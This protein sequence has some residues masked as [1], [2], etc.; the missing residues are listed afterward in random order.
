[1]KLALPQ[2]RHLSLLTAVILIM[3]MILPAFA[4]GAS[5]VSLSDIQNHWASKSLTDWVDKGL[6]QGYEDGTFKPNDEIKRAEF[7]ALV[8]RVFG[9][10]E[11]AEVSFKD[12]TPEKWFAPEIAKAAAAGYITGYEDGTIKPNRE[13]SRQEAAVILA[14]VLS[15]D[16]SVNAGVADPFKDAADIAS[17]SKQAVEAVVA[18]GV[19]QGYPDAT[20]RP[21]ISITRAEAVV[22]L[23]QSLK[24]EEQPATVLEGTVTSNGLP[25]E[26]A[27]VK[28]REKDGYAA[29]D[30][31]LT[32]QNGKY[33]F[34]VEAG[35]YDLTVAKGEAVAFQSDVQVQPDT[36]ASLDFTLVQGVELSGQLLDSSRNAVAGEEVFFTTNPTF[37]TTT[38]EDGHFTAYVLADRNYTLRIASDGTGT[39]EYEVIAT[40][41]KVGT[42]PIELGI[43]NTASNLNVTGGSS[44]KNNNRP[45]VGDPEAFFISGLQVVVDGQ[46]TD[47]IFAQEPTEATVHIS[48]ST[49]GDA[50]VTLYKVDAGNQVVAQLA[51][52]HDDGDRA[53]GDSIKSDG[54]YSGIITLDESEEGF[55]RLQART[56]AQS[57]SVFRLSVVNH[58]TD[59]QFAQVMHQTQTTQDKFNELAAQY[60]GDVQRAKEET[61]AWLGTQPEVESAGVSGENG[62]VWFVMS[63]GILGGIS[64]APDNSKGLSAA[65]ATA[66]SVTAFA[67]QTLTQTGSQVGSKRVAIVS[68]FADVLSSATVYDAVYADI[69]Q[70]DY[71]F[72]VNRVKNAAADV[73]FF[74]GLNQ[75]GLIVLDTHGDT[76][77]D[78]TILQALHEKYG[79][80]FPYAGPQV[81][82]LTGEQAT[83]A[84]RA[85]HEIDLKKGRLA[86]ISGYYA[87][88]PSFITRYNDSMPDSIIFNGS[89]RS[90]FNDSMADAF[91]NNGA[92]TYYGYTNY[93]TLAYD[94]AIVTS[95]MNS[96]IEQGMSTAEAFD[97]AV[98]AHGASDGLASFAMKGSSIGMKTEGIVNGTFENGTWNGWN[99]NGDVRVITQLGPVKP[100]DGSYMA[101]ISTGLG[102]ENNDVN[103]GVFDY[104]S[105]SYIEQNFLIPAGATR[106]SFD[107]NFISEEPTEFVGSVFD[108]TFHA[109][110][111]SSVYVSDNLLPELDVEGTTVTQQV[112]SGLGTVISSG[113]GEYTYLIAAE[114]INASQHY[115]TE[116]NQVDIDFY[117]GDDTAYMTN[118]KHMVVDVSA[119]AGQGP[120]ILRF[121][122][123]DQGDSIYDTAVLIDNIVLE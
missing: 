60:A 32:D 109:T 52:L 61:V 47:A 120:I 107:Y 122:V 7:F 6:V 23:D 21:G 12:V 41:V 74:K 9:F 76:F 46:P 44:K 85:M 65:T 111:T 29:I 96:L 31:A 88:T 33:S 117:G 100:T 2:K 118:W 15:L 20:Y 28:L 77:Y 121:H 5:A 110:V 54:V 92:Q 102:F 49:N 89:C 94:Q 103:G 50:D 69:S 26:G 57:S 67:A 36:A 43:L 93:V 25:V 73:A 45:P 35:T 58:L 80:E 19:M 68:P 18:A 116:E 66:E 17:W 105:D 90:L 112:Y 82:V 37:D 114:S 98:D 4:V 97:A 95:V 72:Q 104:N 108:D 11:E 3:S 39:Q 71:P 51:T 56:G 99:G 91:I 106:L 63:S 81:M 27:Q 16:L 113:N 55:I 123:W 42:D 119:F 101:I 64:I 1:M 14:N 53:N 22:A 70:S 84:N 38:D 34:S 83:S 59:E 75:Y 87:I 62:S 30:N 40:D 115:W 86:I 13:I 78:E 79:I 24:S 10:T 8:N 48:L